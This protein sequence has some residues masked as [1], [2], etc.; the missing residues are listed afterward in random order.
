ME[1]SDHE[2]PKGPTMHTAQQRALIRGTIL[3]HPV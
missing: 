2:I 1:V 3:L